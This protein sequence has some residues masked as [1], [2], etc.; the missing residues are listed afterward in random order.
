MNEDFDIGRKEAFL[1]FLFLSLDADAAF[2]SLSG[3]VFSSQIIRISRAC[4]NID[5][6]VERVTRMHEEF[7]KLGYDRTKLRNVYERVVKKYDLQG[8][9]GVNCSGCL[10]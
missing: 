1:A 9:Y 6:F 4:N 5:M 8:K 3:A 2:N 7:L 10:D